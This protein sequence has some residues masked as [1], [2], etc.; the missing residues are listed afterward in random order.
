MFGPAFGC[1]PL[2]FSYSNLLHKFSTFDAYD[3]AC[4]KNFV[5]ENV[6]GPNVILKEKKSTLKVNTKLVA[7]RLA[8][9]EI[10]VQTKIRR[11]T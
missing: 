11:I 5:V 4:S 1:A 7:H 9:P 6:A 2:V 10:L 3:Q 8:D